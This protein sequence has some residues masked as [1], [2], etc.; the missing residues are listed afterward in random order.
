ME[1]AMTSR[2]LAGLIGP[3]IVALAATE[4]M[5]YK[6]FADNIAPCCS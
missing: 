3:V 1:V 5:N 6:V 2:S 4:A